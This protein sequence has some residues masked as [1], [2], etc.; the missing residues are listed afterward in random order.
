MKFGMSSRIKPKRKY[1]R[2]SMMEIGAQFG[3]SAKR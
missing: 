2:I 3:Q 1:V